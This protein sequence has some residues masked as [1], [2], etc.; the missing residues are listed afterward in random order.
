MKPDPSRLRDLLNYDPETGVFTWAYSRTGCRAGDRCGRIQYTGYREIGIDYGLYRENMIAW[1]YM[2]GEWPDRDVDHINRIRDDNRWCNLR[3]AT[4]T[5]NS[6]NE[7]LR[8]NNTS[9]YKGVTLDVQSGLWRAQIRMAGKKVNLGRFATK[10]EAAKAHDHA[11]IK[12]FGEYAVT[13]RDI[14]A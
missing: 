12:A 5:Q 1:T 8:S 2:T 9:G 7:G 14:H 13:N 10:E 4:R 3:L 6:G 11:A